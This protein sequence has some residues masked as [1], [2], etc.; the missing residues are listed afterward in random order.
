[1]ELTDTFFLIL[2]HVNNKDSNKLWLECYDCIRKLYPKKFIVILDDNSKYNFITEKKLFN[3]TIIQ[4]EFPGAGEI[5]PYYYFYKYKWGNKMIFLHDS[6]FIQKKLNLD[7][8]ISYLF[9]FVD[10]Q[11][12]NKKKEKKLLRQLKKS[13]ELL[14]I[15]NKKKWHGCFGVSSIISYS[16]LNTLVLKYDFLKLINIIK[17]RNDRMCL[18]RIFSV[19]CY[20]ILNKNPKCINF[21]IHSHF[22]SFRYKYENY[23]NNNLDYKI[24]KVW[25]GR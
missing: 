15:Y 25:C 13:S 5:L 7:E 6:M 18:E 2:R 24:I 3:T 11:W 10:H 12:D 1:M 22:D 14:N 23:K 4:S 17:S 16:F 9:N 19:C 21:V 20:T 8:N